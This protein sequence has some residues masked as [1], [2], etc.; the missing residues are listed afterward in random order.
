M[1]FAL[2]NNE[3]VLPA[4]GLKAHCPACGAE[5]I[6]KCGTARVH[7]WAHRGKRVCDHWWETET[8]WHR[9][10][11]EK[12]PPHWQE[13]IHFAENGEKHIADVKT[14]RGLTI[15]FQY[16]HLKPEERVSRELFYKNMIWIVNGVRL[17]RDLPRLLE[18]KYLFEPT[19]AKGVYMTHFPQGAFPRAWLDSAVP[20]F[21]DFRNAP[22]STNDVEQVTRSLWCL[23]P[24]R[25]SG[26]A[27]VMRISTETFVDLA[28]SNG[29]LIDAQA[30][31]G[32]VEQ[33]LIMREAQQR[34]QELEYRRRVAFAA[35]ARR[36]RRW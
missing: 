25:I 7:H 22:A 1:R 27:V 20:V 35:N 26:R 31:L 12:F 23:L 36:T 34:K 3:R 32:T 24:G 28:Q 21:F 9:S 8:E 4:Q 10:W 2:I 33:W 13:I 30:M 16:S 29:Q 6:A 5:M 17:M 19:F 11:K 14:E 15:E 18:G